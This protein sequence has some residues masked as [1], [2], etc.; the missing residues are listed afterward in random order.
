MAAAVTFG[1]AMLRLSPPGRL[2]LEQARELELW[3]AGAELNVAV[4]LARLGTEAAWVSVVP[5][6]PLG[7]LVL[8]HA[9]AHGV[10]VGAV[11]RAEGRLGLYF[12]EPAEPPLPGR[13]LYDRAGSAFAALDPPAFEW[14]ALLARA[15]T[16]HVTGITAAL[17]D[18]PARAVAEA[19]AAARA[20]GCHT[21][22]DLNLRTLLGPPEGWRQ[23]LEAVA[24]SVDTLLLSLDD[25]GAVFGLEGEPAEVAVRLRSRL[26]VERV[27]V[28][29]RVPADGG[30]RREA[31]AADETGTH[32][33]S[34][35]VF[36]G[37]EPVGAGDAFAAGFLHGLLASGP[38]RG[39]ELGAAMAAVKQ[40]IP[41]DAPVIDAADLELALGGGPRMLR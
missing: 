20:A 11:V 14:P 22:Y 17:G 26:G 12:V 41:G 25:A 34:S 35:P 19:L 2:R 24:A 6:N 21:S 18:G 10:D 1:E 3:P 27:V 8:A 28:S 33:V 13:A 31:V 15:A 9:R 4:G 37:A 40:A 7:E 29:R 16:F 30:L 39:L 36:G 5:R 38:E 32:A 23:R